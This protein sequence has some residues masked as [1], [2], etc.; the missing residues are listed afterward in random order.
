MTK[1][2]KLMSLAALFAVL[3]LT[4]QAQSLSYTADL[5]NPGW[6]RSMEI[7]V[8]STNFSIAINPT[9]L[10]VKEAWILVGVTTKMNVSSTTATN[11]WTLTL[12]PCNFDTVPT[13]A[14]LSTYSMG[15]LPSEIAGSELPRVFTNLPP[16][17][18]GDTF[19]MKGNG[20][21][22]LATNTTVLL[23]FFRIMPYRNNYGLPSI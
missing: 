7:A 19:T 21:T 20:G 14:G 10:T 11:Q 8:P 12:T 15:T 13:T 1:F 3:A 6:M 23:N 22:A 16:I 9:N 4:S 2:L 5:P 17:R 18:A